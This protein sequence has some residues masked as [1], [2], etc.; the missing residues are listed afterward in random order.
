MSEFW[1]E[2]YNTDLYR[3]GVEPNQFFKESLLHYPAGNLLL[4]AEGEG[5]NAVFAAKHGWQAEAFDLSETGQKKALAL[6]DEAGVRINYHIAGY[7]S[8]H[9]P[10]EQFDS[11]GLI[12]AHLPLPEK[13]VYFRRLIPFLKKG[14]YIIF[15]G[16][17]KAHSQFQ[18]INES[19]GG[20]R[21]QDMLFSTDELASIFEGLQITLL[22]Q[23]LITLQEGVGHK[24]KASVVRM[25]ARKV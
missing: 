8:V 21:N 22:E 11:I 6:A 3:Y 1:N 15:E 2:R 17:S 25:I 18:Q 4:P 10:N 16:F 20:P 14:G 23:R 7:E 12:Y 13:N 9:Y 19:A 24:G 5:R